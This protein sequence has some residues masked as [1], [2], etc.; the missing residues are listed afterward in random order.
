[1]KEILNELI[2]HRSLT[3]E[4]AKKVLVELT[5]GKFNPS[6]TAAFM[7]PTNRSRTITSATLGKI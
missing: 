4:T 3:K 2:N 1:M 7:T 5:S 6:Q